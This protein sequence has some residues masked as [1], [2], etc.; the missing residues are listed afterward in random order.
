MR[1]SD[2]EIR[3]RLMS[4]TDVGDVPLNFLELVQRGEIPYD[5]EQALK[6]G[7]II[8]DPF[9]TDLNKT[10][11]SSSIDLDFGN[12][13]E[14]IRI[15]L[16][17]VNIDGR[18]IIRRHTVDFRNPNSNTRLLENLRSIQV[19]EDGS[20]VRFRLNDEDTFELPT[21]LLVLAFTRQIICIPNDLD[22]SLQGRSTLARKGIANHITSDRF[23]AGFVGYLTMEVLNQGL[24]NVNIFPGMD[25]AAISF[26]QLSS[27]ASVPYYKKIGA[28]FRGQH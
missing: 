1:L 27:P 2:N 8:I 21:G 26:N 18:S 28:K 11:S 25:F 22:A 20:W 6:K 14:V 23:D 15:P 24:A 19:K 4:L 16:E 9:P 17:I 10:I 7:H 13:I 5:L 3:Q 12:T